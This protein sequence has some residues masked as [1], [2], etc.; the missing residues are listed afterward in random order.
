ML[1]RLR[2]CVLHVYVATQPPD[3]KKGRKCVFFVFLAVLFILSSLPSLLRSFD[4]SFPLK[5]E[6]LSPL[7]SLSFRSLALIRERT[8]RSPRM[9]SGWCG[10]R[11][12]WE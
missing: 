5:F 9:Q 4:S 2:A 8:L 3:R 7:P 10:T 6:F 12:R 11:G 1:L